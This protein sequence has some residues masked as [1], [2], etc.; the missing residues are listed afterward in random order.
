MQSLHGWRECG[1][2]EDVR[3]QRKSSAMGDGRAGA[4]AGRACKPGIGCYSACNG[5]AAWS[6]GLAEEGRDVIHVLPRLPLTRGG[7]MDCR[8]SRVETGRPVRS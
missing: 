8:G 2:L 4:K 6:G 3:G 7:R 5:K 1:L